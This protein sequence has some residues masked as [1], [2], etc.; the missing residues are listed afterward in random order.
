MRA[1]PPVAVPPFTSQS[2]RQGGGPADRG[3]SRQSRA[4]CDLDL[5]PASPGVIGA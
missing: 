5:L 2:C 1:E 4:A 3:P